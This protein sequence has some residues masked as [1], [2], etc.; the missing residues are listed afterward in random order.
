VIATAA[1]CLAA[2]LPAPVIAQLSN[3]AG[4]L[5]CEKA[6]VVP[7]DKERLKKEAEKI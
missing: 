3:L 2:S 7:I 6:G 5:V 4:G 1:L